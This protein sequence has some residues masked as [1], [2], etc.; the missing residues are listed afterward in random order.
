MVMPKD[1]IPNAIVGS[2]RTFL[3]SMEESLGLLEKE[4]DDAL[5]SRDTCTAQWCETAEEAMD[6]LSKILFSISEPRWSNPEDSARLKH[7]KRRLHDAY[8]DYKPLFE[9]AR[10][11]E[12][13][14]ETSMEGFPFCRTAPDPEHARAYHD[15]EPCDDSR[16]GP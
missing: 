2:W 12:K 3:D 11:A 16:E 13:Q 1:R 4:I 14:G 10:S 5:R 15:D 7:L 8:A 9:T 6:E